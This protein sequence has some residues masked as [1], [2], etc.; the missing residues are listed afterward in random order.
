MICDYQCNLRPDGR[1]DADERLELCRGTTEFIV[2]TKFMVSGSLYCLAYVYQ[3]STFLCTK[4]RSKLQRIEFMNAVQTG[5]AVLSAEL[6]QIF[7]W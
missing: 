5:P 6:S 3:N 4:Q 7:L 2:T 1:R